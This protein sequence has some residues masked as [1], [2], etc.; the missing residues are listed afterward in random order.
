MAEDSAAEWEEREEQPEPSGEEHSEEEN[1]L[2]KGPGPVDAE[3]VD[4]IEPSPDV[5][6]LATFSEQE[7][8]FS[9]KVIPVIRDVT[10]DWRIVI[11]MRGVQGPVYESTEKISDGAA[12]ELGMSRRLQERINKALDYADQNLRIPPELGD[13]S[14]KKKSLHELEM[15]MEEE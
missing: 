2:K 1:E 10:T 9:Y 5:E 12:D 11:Y 8:P 4:E 7:G 13:H 6:A 3:V 14:R 15:M